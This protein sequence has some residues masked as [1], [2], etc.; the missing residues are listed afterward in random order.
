MTQPPNQPGEDRAEGI[1]PQ[2]GVPP[3]PGPGAPPPSRPGQPGGYGAAAYSLPPQGRF[4]LGDAI[5]W[6]WNKF[7]KN[8]VALIVPIL[9]YALVLFV[10]FGLAYVFLR[11][12]GVA[13]VIQESDGTTSVDLTGVGATTVVVASFVMSLVAY[14]SL[15]AYVSGLL[16][17]ADGQRVGVGSFFAPRNAGPAMLGALL[18]ALATSL[19]AAIPY[20]GYIASVVVGLITMYVLPTI[21]DRETGVVEGF[22]E[23]FAVFQKDVGNAILVYIVAALM[24]LVGS[25]LCG[26]GVLVAAP[27]AALV[28]VSAYRTISGGRVAPK[29]P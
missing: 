29:T 10:V 28:V 17:I 12:F 2:G 9:L 5:S 13:D 1:P 6:A 8:A 21:V 14:A 27:V 11:R 15:V 24:V 19:V 16:D 4:N 3:Q 25:A 20:V 23:G 18:L 26:L 22:K 7:T